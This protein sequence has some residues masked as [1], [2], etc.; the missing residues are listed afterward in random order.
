M[1][2]T[3]S[4]RAIWLAGLVLLL[5]GLL[6]PAFVNRQPIMYPDSV[7]YFHS[8]YAA[9]K[10][11]KSILDAHQGSPAPTAPALTSRQADGVTTA[12]SVYYGLTYVA[13]YWLG[14]V[15]ALALGQALVVLAALVLAARHAVPLD[16]LR[17]IAVL[18]ALVVLTGLN[19]FA[20]AAMPDLF[21]GL[22]LLAVALV[23]AY[24]P[25]MTRLEYAFWLGLIALAGL[26]HKAHLAIL[27]VTLVLAAPLVWRRRGRDLLLLA[28][29][30]L[31]AWVGHMAVDVAVTK[32]TGKPPIAPPFLLARLV[33]DGTAER[34]LRDVCPKRKLATCAFLDKMP[35]TEN[36]FLWSREPD[37]S[38]MG[39]ADRQTRA[40]I[41][42]ES[43]AIVLG[44]L[45]AYGGEEAAAAARNVMRQLGDVGVS[46]Y[47]LTP[48]DEVAPIPMLAWALDH[49]AKSAIAQGW[50]PLMEISVLMRSVYFAALVGIGMMLWQRGRGQ[51]PKDS[52]EVG[53]VLLLLIGIAANALV[54]G[55]ISGVFDRYQGRVAW[56]ASLGFAVLLVKMLNE[57]RSSSNALK[58]R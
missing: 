58:V 23:L 49:Y 55:A 30:G 15:W 47:G 51:L 18:G 1:N 5:V 38:V 40:A 28:G 10:Q 8:G 57:R 11:A 22:M 46:E 20:V 54:A 48:K 26:Y 31:L 7:G 21:A 41:A 56:L 39:G 24:A 9:I 17:R 14:G 32:A 6:L 50:M 13:G 36:D 34:Y 35:M 25:Q 2:E 4:A 27:A 12:R 3:G 44:T 16:P 43:G 42:A 19:V 37:R 33:G 45:Q 52:D 29:A 53:F